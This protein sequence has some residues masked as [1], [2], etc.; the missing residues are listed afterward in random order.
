MSDV[1]VRCRLLE[2]R[3]NK[4]PAEK[5]LRRIDREQHCGAR[6]GKHD[7]ERLGDT[8]PHAGDRIG[9]RNADDPDHNEREQAVSGRTR[10][11][12]APEAHSAVERGPRRSPSATT[13]TAGARVTVGTV[14]SRTTVF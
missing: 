5:E 3:G 14:F 4:E 7:N 1:V 12:G 2:D 6:E 13:S 8:R 9:S 10:K 11:D